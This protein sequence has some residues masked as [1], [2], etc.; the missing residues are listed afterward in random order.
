MTEEQIAQA[1]EKNLLCR[2]IKQL[3]SDDPLA[4]F[5]ACLGIGFY[6]STEMISRAGRV[7]GIYLGVMFLVYCVTF[8]WACPKPDLAG[9]V[10]AE[11]F[12]FA[13]SIML[14]RANAFSFNFK[15]PKLPAWMDGFVAGWK[16]SLV[17]LQGIKLLVL[18]ALSILVTIDF[19]GFA[20]AAFCDTPWTVT[21]YCVPGSQLIGL[22]P[23]ATLE[24]LA[25]AYVEHKEF[26]RAEKLYMDILAV[27]SRVFGATSGP[28]G[29][30]YADLGDLSVRESNFKNAEYWYRKSVDLSE[31]PGGPAATGRA[32]T[33]LATVLRQ[34]GSLQESEQC[35]KKA[36]CIRA[37]IYGPASRQYHDTERAYE[38]LL[39]LK[40]HAGSNQ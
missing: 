14:I 6:P 29:A 17:A 40:Q 22:H 39:G 2:Q 4:G 34:S 31:A 12:L 24:V 11:V 23:A 27:R 9:A 8:L 38:Q 36:L 30:L 15:L 10:G 16:K 32:L 26:H 20:S 25:G 33:G 18:V 21:L 7:L 19:T 35:Y 28:V 3:R 1:V 5:L 37:R 13:V